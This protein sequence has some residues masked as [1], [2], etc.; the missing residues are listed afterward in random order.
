VTIDKEA[1]SGPHENA[2]PLIDQVVSFP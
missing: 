2:Y 1:L